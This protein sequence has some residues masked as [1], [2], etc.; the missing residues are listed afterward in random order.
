MSLYW[1]C[2]ALSLLCGADLV[3]SLAVALSRA[4]SLFPLSAALPAARAAGGAAGVGG[5]TGRGACGRRSCSALPSGTGC[6]VSR[7]KVVEGI[8]QAR[9]ALH[10][11]IQQYPESESGHLTLTAMP[12]FQ[13]DLGPGYVWRSGGYSTMITSNA[14]PKAV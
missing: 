7:G 9:P 3:R 2:L 12:L 10:T 5:T 1:T 13:C 4:D 6:I 14:G 8:A 11:L